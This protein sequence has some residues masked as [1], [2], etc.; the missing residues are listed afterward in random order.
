[1]HI[2]ERHAHYGRISSASAKPVTGL[3]QADRGA[4]MAHTCRRM[5]T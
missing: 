4:S 2:K 5:A 3:R 1:M